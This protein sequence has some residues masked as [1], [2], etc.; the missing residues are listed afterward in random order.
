VD[1]NPI[2]F[3]RIKI[4]KKRLIKIQEFARLLNVLS[5]VASDAI[6][7]NSVWDEL[8]KKL[9]SLISFKWKNFYEETGG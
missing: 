1:F 6:K 7:K 2:H 8:T 4:L 9:Q 3:W 5:Y